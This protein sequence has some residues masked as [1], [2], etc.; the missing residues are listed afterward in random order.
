MISH[1][2]IP[3]V[4]KLFE[5]N[6]TLSCCLV[7]SLQHIGKFYHGLPW[8]CF[9][10]PLYLFFF[11]FYKIFHSLYLGTLS[12]GQGHLHNQRYCV[13]TILMVHVCFSFP[14]MMPYLLSQSS[15]YSSYPYTADQLVL[16][17]IQCLHTA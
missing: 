4:I 8:K 3:W 2:F 17:Y 7:F 11:V 14:Y 13:H 1:L 16:I 6:V 15:L 9:I 5:A 12:R 10:Q